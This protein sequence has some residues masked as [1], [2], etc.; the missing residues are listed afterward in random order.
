[1]I[2]VTKLMSKI[3]ESTDQLLKF[4]KKNLSYLNQIITKKLL[5]KE[6]LLLIN[7]MLQKIIY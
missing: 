7:K 6:K 1:M 5:K 4:L 3:D 2:I